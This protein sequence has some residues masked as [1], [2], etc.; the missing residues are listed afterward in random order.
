MIDSLPDDLK[1]NLIFIFI[2][3]RDL[4]NL[5]QCNQRFHQLI[6]SSE[7]ESTEL[8]WQRKVRLDYPDE[9]ACRDEINDSWQEYYRWLAITRS[10]PIFYQGSILCKIRFKDYLC[11]IIAKDLHQEIPE[12][13]IVVFTNSFLEPVVVIQDSSIVRLTPV[14]MEISKVVIVTQLEPR[15]NLKYILT[16]M[17]LF[18]S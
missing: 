1:N 11:S 14:N 16:S 13:N 15:S 12:K 8:L 6:Q 2:P 17:I 18:T 5:S 7:S 3:T 4:L 10:V 9:V